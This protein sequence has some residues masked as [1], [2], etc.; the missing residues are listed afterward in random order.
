MEGQRVLER[1]SWCVLIVNPVRE[2][3]RERVTMNISNHV[4]DRRRVLLGQYK[5]FR[6]DFFKEAPVGL[7]NVEIRTSLFG[8]LHF[9]I[10]FTIV[11]LYHG[12]QS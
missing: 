5:V 12:V 2:R 8:L 9:I 1:L 3:E 4:D 7:T 11:I 10:I 6:M